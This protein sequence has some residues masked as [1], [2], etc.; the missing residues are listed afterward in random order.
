[1]QQQSFL[2]K[3]TK[4]AFTQTSGEMSRTFSQNS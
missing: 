2:A 4:Q 1:M 3:I